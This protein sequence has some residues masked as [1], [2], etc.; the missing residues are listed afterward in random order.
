MV[1][2]KIARF[3]HFEDR[4]FQ[5]LKFESFNQEDIE[6]IL[7][8]LTDLSFSDD[9]INYLATRTNQFRQLVKLINKIEKLSQT[10]QFKEIDEQ[11]LKGI[12]NERPSSKVMSK[13]EKLYTC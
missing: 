4:L 11:L 6:V 12:L 3:K 10:N 13:I 5:K 2:K 7:K 1:D 9:A 8:E